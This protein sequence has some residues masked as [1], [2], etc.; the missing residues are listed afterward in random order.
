M[1]EPSPAGD[2]TLNRQG[3]PTDAAHLVAVCSD[4]HHAELTVRERLAFPAERL[5]DGLR[6]LGA[7]AREVAIVSTCN[8]VEVYAVVHAPSAVAAI[9]TVEAS[10]AEATGLPA[11]TV[12][13]ATVALSGD[14]AVRHLFRVAAGLESMV[15]GEP[16]ILGQLRD[17]FAAAR[18]HGTSGPLLAR[19]GSDALR[20]G[21]QARTQTDIARNKTSIA[22]AAVALAAQEYAAACPILM[23]LDRM[24]FNRLPCPSPLAHSYSLRGRT[25]VVVGAGPM[26]TLA[27]KL[28][29]SGEIG[30][31]IIV[32]RTASRAAELAART[33]GEAWPLDRLP[34]ALADADLAIVAT[35]GTEPGVTTATL[36][37]MDR[38]L[39]HPLVMVDVGVPRCVD[40]AVGGDDRVL[41]RDVDDLEQIATTF[42]S[43]QA[44]QVI[45]VEHLIADAT[46]AF[47][48]WLDARRVA[49]TVAALRDHGDAI[50]QGELDRA[51]GRLSH[52]SAR[53]REVVVALAAGLTN[54]LL[55]APTAT[56]TRAD[57]A[58][59]AGDAAAVLRLFGLPTANGPETASPTGPAGTAEVAAEQC[60][61]HHGATDVIARPVRDISR[62]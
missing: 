9:R 33:G 44:A 49:P 50:R 45:H 27:A 41:L 34:G 29:R 24:D 18:E 52:L 5:G 7:V 42:R 13:D 62:R 55:H 28:L 54:K 26:G 59:R 14:P 58:D 32:N 22:H 53:D 47:H 31:L 23:A 6:T 15:L 21:K 56:M 40:P 8:R 16:Q 61:V 36:A 37:A 60:P 3:E 38:R 2:T 1:P 12:A 43:G 35:G 39:L 19:L 11:D 17:A 48:G 4:Y 25:A 10:L 57:N 20:V 51:L 46:I 30:R